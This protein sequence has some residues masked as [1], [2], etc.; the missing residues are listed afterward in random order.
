M[1]LIIQRALASLQICK[2]SVVASPARVQSKQ[3]QEA[4]GM[5]RRA[6]DG[7]QQ[8]EQTALFKLRLQGCRS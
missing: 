5:Y 7:G 4:L 8:L 3:G 2:G 6:E 1:G